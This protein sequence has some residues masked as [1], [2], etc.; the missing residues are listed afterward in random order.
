[1][2]DLKVL[3]RPT[4]E[5]ID[6]M[7]SSLNI[8]NAARVSFNKVSNDLDERD[9]KLMV[10][11]AKHKHWSPFAHTSLSF[12]C[13]APIFLARQLVKHQVGGV[14][15]EVSRR[16]VD[17][18]PEFYCPT[19]FHVRAENV[20]QGCGEVV[21]LLDNANFS[22]VLRDKSK[23]A[24][25]AYHWLLGNGVAPEEARMVLPLNTMTEWVWTGSLLF[26]HRV[27]ALRSEAHAQTIAREFA[28]YLDAEISRSPYAKAWEILKEYYKD[29]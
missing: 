13:K 23:E 16:Y 29:V 20:K 9:E 15:N 24:L 5:L 22:L 26:F 11:L 3:D 17:D 28:K 19:V 7:G 10:Y 4:V 12:R 25:Q 6:G 21:D 1:M 18:D 8:V 14:W 27:W 2:T